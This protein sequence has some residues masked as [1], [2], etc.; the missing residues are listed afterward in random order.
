MYSICH[1][2]TYWCAD[3]GCR[4]LPYVGQVTIIMNDYPYLKYALI[5]VLALFVI[6]SKD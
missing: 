6:M 1:Y 5:G 3:D 4:F 2:V